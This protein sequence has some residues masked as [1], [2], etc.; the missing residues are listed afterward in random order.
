LKLLRT[1]ITPALFVVALAAACG[2]PGSSAP[3]S[4]PTGSPAGSTQAS[5]GSAT[6]VNVVITNDGCAPDQSSV[7][8][9]SVTFNVSNDGADKV[10]ELELKQDEHTVAEKENLT[11]GLSGSFTVTLATGEYI[12]ECPGAA[13]DESTFTV[14]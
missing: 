6:T 13:T 12:L 5:S 14:V 11:P 9:G 4:G 8:A 7:A 1:P 3:A 10:S 2:T